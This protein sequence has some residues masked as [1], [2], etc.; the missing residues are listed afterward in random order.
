M[1]ELSVKVS[2]DDLILTEKFLLNEEG[3]SLSHDDLILK[4]MVDGVIAKFKGQPK[5]VL[6]RIKYTW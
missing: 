3:I 4:Q 1:I 2:D 5:D 6:L